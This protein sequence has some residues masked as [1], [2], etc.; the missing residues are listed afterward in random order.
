MVAAG[1]LQL[2][3]ADTRRDAPLIYED[4]A[5]DA[6]RSPA[7]AARRN[8]DTSAAR[9]H[10][11]APLSPELEHI[12]SALTSTVCTFGSRL[13]RAIVRDGTRGFH[14][15]VEAKGKAG[16]VAQSVGATLVVDAGPLPS[17]SGWV[18]LGYLQSCAPRVAC[19]I[20]CTSRPPVGPHR[21][22]LPSDVLRPFAHRR[23]EDGGCVRRVLWRLC[24]RPYKHRCAPRK[25]DVAFHPARPRCHPIRPRWRVVPSAIDRAGGD[26]ERSAQV[27]GRLPDHL[28][29]HHRPVQPSDGLVHWRAICEIIA[30]GGRVLNGPSHEMGCL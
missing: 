18:H 4:A 25:T 30:C 10:A 7:L 22:S 28:G 12:G 20:A 11:V 17:S 19:R 13:E 1:L 24:V 26:A 27:Q 14:F 9:L 15:V 23:R 29:E 5:L 8:V 21:L 2:R 6:A 16:I 3:R